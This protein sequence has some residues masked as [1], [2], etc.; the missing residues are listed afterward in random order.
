MLSFVRLLFGH[1]AAGD[2]AEAPS[3]PAPPGR[4]QYDEQPVPLNASVDPADPEYYYEWAEQVMVVPS[5]DG[6][7]V[8]VHHGWLLAE[9]PDTHEIIYHE[10][11]SMMRPD[12]TDWLKRIEGAN[13]IYQHLFA[14]Q[15]SH[16]RIVGYLG[17]TNTGYRLE[18][19]NPGPIYDRE[20]DVDSSDLALALYQCWGLQALSAL[21][22]IHS[23]GAVLN[24]LASD[25]L[26]LR[27]DF[28]IAVAGF[29]CAACAEIRVSAQGSPTMN[30]ESFA[31]PW[32]AS[33]TRS[34]AAEK[35]TEAET[36]QPKKDLFD[37][38][39]WVCENMTG[40]SPFQHSMTKS[41]QDQGYYAGIRPLERA[42]RRGEYNDW[43]SMP[44]QK[45]GPIVL[46]ALRGQYETASEALAE[47]KVLLQGLGRT[48]ASSQE[49]E[50]QDYDWQ[51]ELRID[52]VVAYGEPRKVLRVAG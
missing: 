15:S 11:A 2:K 36:G 42:L 3:L 19:L 16:P 24:A 30:A 22:F 5:N 6:T 25:S 7:S 33:R 50:L 17:P 8:L 1:Q 45:L 35:Y 21:K 38:A 41:Q 9:D 26:W 37:W 18:R 39:V 49:D 13:T 23:R 52:M 48:L 46:K 10:H 12:E 28:S 40:K 27:E 4:R 29:M 43:P 34:L 51:K 47:L 20:L 14:S 44:D 32:A 31:C